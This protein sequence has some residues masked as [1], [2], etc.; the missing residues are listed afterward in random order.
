MKLDR[1][2]A[3]TMLL[4]NRKRVSARELAARFEVSARTILRDIETL[5]QAGIP[6]VSYQG[7]NGGFGIMENYKL[8]R[9]LLSSEDLHSIITALRGLHTTLDDRRVADTLE[10]IRTLVPEMKPEGRTELPSNT[11]V[12]FS[13][14]G[15]S[16]LQKKKL[17]MIRTAIHENRL[18]SFHYINSRGECLKRVVEPMVMV[19]KGYSWY[20]HAYCRSRE[21]F[22]FFKLTRVKDLQVENERFIRRSMPFDASNTDFSWEE[23]TLMVRILLRFSPQARLRVEDS[24]DEDMIRLQKDGSLLVEAHYPQNDWAWGNILS[25]GPDVEVLE[26]GFVREKIGE[27]ARQMWQLYQAE[28]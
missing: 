17:G 8:D 16:S 15:S 5:N 13:P 25:F 23:D 24:F 10:K 6:I 1:L 14:W 2:L 9:Q 18:I 3:I 27:K 20:F 12:D 4:I 21:D 7:T 19:L 26:P 11:V 22:R 28:F